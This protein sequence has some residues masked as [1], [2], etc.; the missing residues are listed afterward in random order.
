MA[1]SHVVVDVLEQCATIGDLHHAI[2]SGAM[3]RSDVYATL[4][5]VVSGRKP[6]PALEDRPIIFDSTGTALEDMA[7]ARVTY[8]RARS[9]GRGQPIPIFE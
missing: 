1:S 5:D 9:L 6:R 8:E 3:T 7:A 4:A 2:S